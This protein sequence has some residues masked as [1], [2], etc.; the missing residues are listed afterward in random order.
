M[1]GSWKPLLWLAGAM[2]LGVFGY[3]L[4]GQR[5]PQSVVPDPERGGEW[6]LPDLPGPRDAAI[7]ADW[8][9]LDPWNAAPPAVAEAPPSLPPAVPVGVM[10]VGRG[11]KAVFVQAGVE[12]VAGPG[13]RLHGGGQVRSVGPLQVRWVD[14]DGQAHVRELFADPLQDLPPPGASTPEQ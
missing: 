12:Q 14:A 10:R 7:G 6:S 2:L 4:F 11:W 1:T 9:V 13:E 8:T 3:S 5:P